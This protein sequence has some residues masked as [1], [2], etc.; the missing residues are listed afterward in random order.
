MEHQNQAEMSVSDGDDNDGVV[1][2]TRDGE[3]E[4]FMERLTA[5]LRGD[6]TSPDWI[7]PNIRRALDGWADGSHPYVGDFLRAVLENNLT[8]AFGRA[9]EYNLRTLHAIVAYVYNELP[10]PSHGSPE[11]VRTW[12]AECLAVLEDKRTGASPT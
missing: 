5:S 3:T 10:S 4:A 8:E 12:Q 2:R 9:D 7:R 1:H 11:K 6:V